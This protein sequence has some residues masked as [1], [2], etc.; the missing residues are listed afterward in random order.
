MTI[1]RKIKLIIVVCLIVTTGLV[2]GLVVSKKSNNEQASNNSNSSASF[3]QKDAPETP[4]VP[5]EKNPKKNACDLLENNL[6]A[7]IIG[8]GAVKNDKLTTITT[9]D[10][11]STICEYT[12][13]NQKVNI[14]LYEYSDKGKVE[15]SKSKSQTEMVVLSPDGKTSS[16]QPRQSEAAVKDKY[17]VSASVISGS[18]YSPEN[19]KKVLDEAMKRL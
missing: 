14:I 15:S 5:I 11:H 3:D 7:E 10:Y 6:V 18:T 17:I 16:V 8:Q 2:I 9:A 1:S 19:S 4:I 12:A 13:N